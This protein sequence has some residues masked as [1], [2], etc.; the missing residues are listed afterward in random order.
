MKPISFGRALYYPHIFP[1]DRR[2]LRTAA[3]Y[4]DGLARIVPRNFLPTEYDR[5]GSIDILRDFEALQESGFIDD[6]HPDQVLQDVGRQFLEFI[7]PSFESAERSRLV[8]QIDSGEWRPYSMFRQKID[9][10]LLALLE[11]QRLVRPINDYEVEFDGQVGGLY[12]LFLAKQMAKQRPIV[13]DNPT[14]EAL[15][16]APPN[17]GT[18]A[19]GVADPGLVLANFVFRTAVP[20]DIESIP[21]NEVIKFR[22]DFEGE[23]VSFYDGISK[24]TADLVAMKDSKLL[25]QAIQHHASA[26]EQKVSSLEKKLRF[27]RLTSGRN[28]FSVSVPTSIAGA[29]WGLGIT[30]PF[31]L[32][33]VGSLIVTGMLISSRFEQ[34]LA[35]ADSTVAYIHSLRKELLPKAYANKFIE[36]NLAGRTVH[37]ELSIRERLRQ[38]W[39]S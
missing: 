32:V 38:L 37:G 11:Q 1:Q 31:I 35:K 39:S 26:I 2:W 36:L 21:I 16:Y 6:E 17:L 22:A 23:R 25:H 18:M 28:I 20:V 14:F 8:S 24:L 12:M 7:A 4:H 30:N 15:T 10:S 27:L 3:L 29:A 19:D 9:P 13:S 5:H 33:P 34:Q